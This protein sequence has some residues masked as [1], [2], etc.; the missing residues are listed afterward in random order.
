MSKHIGRLSDA[1]ARIWTSAEVGQLGYLVMLSLV[2]G[3]PT[4]LVAAGFNWVINLSQW[5]FL[6]FLG[7][8]AAP[9]A[10][11]EGGHAMVESGLELR[12]WV[13]FGLPIAGGLLSGW[14]VFR[15]APEAEGHGTDQVIDAY[16]RHFGRI[17]ARVPL[18]KTLTSAITIGT[19]GCAGREGPVAQVGAGF[20]SNAASLLNLSDRRR[21]VLLL[22][23]AAA[24]IGAIFRAPLGGA[25]F[26]VEV[27]YRES[28]FEYEALIP[29]FIASIVAYSVYCP[30]SGHGWGAIFHA[31][32]FA[33]ENP[34]LLLFYLALALV[35]F[36]GGRVYLEVFYA[37]LNRLFGRMPI[38]RW[39]KPAIGGLLLAIL[40]LAFSYLTGPEKMGAVYGAGYG[41]LQQ[42]IDGAL[43]LKFLL[44]LAVFKILACSVTIGSGG[45]GGVFGPSIVIGGLIGGAFGLVCHQFFPQ[46]VTASTASAFALVG[47][48]GFWAG[49]ANVPVASLLMV[50][51]MTAGYTLLVPLMLVTAVAYSLSYR[52]RSIYEKQVPTRVDS[53]AHTGDFVTDVLEGIHVREVLR[54]DPV[55]TVHEETSVSDL[56]E[57]VA[58]SRQVCFPV[59]DHEDRLTGLVSLHDIRSVFNEPELGHLLIAKDIAETRVPTVTTGETLNVALRRFITNNAEELPVVDEDAPDRVVAMLN[60]RDLIMAYNRELQRQLTL[61]QEAAEEGGRVAG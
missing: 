27:L 57:H 41:Y 23:G 54:P 14:I 21:R 2:V 39:L 52:R 34:V 18:V 11:G 45:S 12:R 49:V 50:S 46:T 30:L 48:A 56:L 60:R 17:R 43:D 37:S 20:A 33:F 32:E 61:A 13:L 59:L 55:D 42:A 28:E 15:F 1:L 53:P 31:Q 5:F 9:A 24:G 29:C 36:V 10:G 40:A 51:E 35:V 19:G 47:M 26:A 25:V 3:V 58:D 4:G 16:H 38:S 22:A 44:L 6:E 7:H 8:Y